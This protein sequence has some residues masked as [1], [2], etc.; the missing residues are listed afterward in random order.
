MRRSEQPAVKTG[1]VVI[2]KDDVTKRLF[3]KLAVVTEVICGNDN[4]IRAAV[5]RVADPQGKPS[6]LRR[7]IKHLYPLEVQST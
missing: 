5:V 1:D 7:S 4:Q 2:V 3:W 6:L